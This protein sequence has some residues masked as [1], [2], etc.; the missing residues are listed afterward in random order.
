VTKNCGNREEKEGQIKK[1][2]MAL[3]ADSILAMTK[4]GK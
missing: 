3:D 4:H 2:P 1:P